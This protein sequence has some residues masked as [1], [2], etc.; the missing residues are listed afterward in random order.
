[1]ITST[2]TIVATD[3]AE[4]GVAVASRVLAVGAIVPEADARWG[5]V[6]TQATVNVGWKRAG[7]SLLKRGKSAQQTVDQLV[8]EDASPDVRQLIVLDRGGR[9]AA[10]SGEE[11]QHWSGHI[12]GEGFAVAGNLL[13]GEEVI[14]SMASCYQSA[15]GSLAQRLLLSLESGDSAGGDRRGRQSAAV[16]IVRLSGG[17]DGLDDRVC[18]LRVDDHPDP[19]RELRRLAG[20][21]FGGGTDGVRSPPPRPAAD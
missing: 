8:A 13:A 12:V 3:G 11:C 20:I 9:A 6:A 15:A 5:V 2:F 10:H 7:M 21:R 1:V 18:D 4:W 16:Q 14:E 17:L 19:V